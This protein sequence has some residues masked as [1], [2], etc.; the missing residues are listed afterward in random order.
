MQ[1][2][3][4]MA[5]C[6]Q[7]TMA[8]PSSHPA[9]QCADQVKLWHSTPAGSATQHFSVGMSKEILA[10]PQELK[11]SQLTHLNSALL[12]QLDLPE[13]EPFWFIGAGKTKVQ[14]F[15]VKP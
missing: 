5:T 13:M 2:V 10:Y 7:P 3:E 11:E 8:R 12:D 15:A 6:I 4:S 9:C 1:I 14:G